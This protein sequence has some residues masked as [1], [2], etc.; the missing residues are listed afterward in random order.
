MSNQ[1][2]NG[3]FNDKRKIPSKIYAD[4]LTYNT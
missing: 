2:M 3:T 4:M 1:S